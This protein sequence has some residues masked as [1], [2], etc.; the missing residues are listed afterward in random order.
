MMYVYIYV[1]KGNEQEGGGHLG[2]VEGAGAEPEA[3]GD[4]RGFEVRNVDRETSAATPHSPLQIIFFSFQRISFQ[5]IFV[6]LY[7]RG[8]R[9]S[10][11]A[12]R[13]PYPVGA[14]GCHATPPVSTNIPLLLKLTE[15]P[16]LL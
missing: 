1:Q 11:G 13:R 9:R 15:V 10:R 3:A 8:P 2:G 4:R 14:F 5:I 16:P 6:S 7:G 12:K